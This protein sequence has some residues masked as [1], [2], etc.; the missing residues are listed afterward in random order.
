MSLDFIKENIT[1]ILADCLKMLLK[2]SNSSCST[3][4]HSSCSSSSSFLCSSFSSSYFHVFFLFT[5]FYSFI[6]L[7]CI[8]AAVFPP[9]SF[10]GPSPKPSI[11]PFSV[12]TPNPLLLC[13]CLGKNRSSCVSRKHGIPSCKKTSHVLRVGN[14]TQYGE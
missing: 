6:Y 8:L 5:L 3:F 7:F 13:F 14:V 9:S 1:G 11:F 2:S 10:P 12:L 4:S